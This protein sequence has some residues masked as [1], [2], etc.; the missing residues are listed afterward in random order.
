MTIENK[1]WY[2]QNVK[3]ADRL[4]LIYNMLVKTSL[5]MHRHTSLQLCYALEYRFGL[6]QRSISTASW[7]LANSNTILN[8]IY[9][10]DFQF[11]SKS[12][13]EFGNHLGNRKKCFDIFIDNAIS[14]FLHISQEES[15]YVFSQKVISISILLAKLKTY[16]MY[17]K[18]FF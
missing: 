7:W 3:F 9:M 2:A 11:C 8:W 14:H 16:Y 4:N 5:F 6:H 15:E 10:K 17:F 18:I 1:L 12:H 13:C